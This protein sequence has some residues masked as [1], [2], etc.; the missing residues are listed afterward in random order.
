MGFFKDL[1]VVALAQQEGNDPP[2]GISGIASIT[3]LQQTTG[4]DGA[5]QTELIHLAAHRFG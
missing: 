3:I 5:V 2:A 1:A 4:R